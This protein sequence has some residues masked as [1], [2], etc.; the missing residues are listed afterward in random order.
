MELRELETFVVLAEELHFGRTGERLRISTAQ[1]SKTVS[2]LER[3]V[4][5]PLF[6]RTSRRVRLT[7]V[8]E[9]LRSD[10]GP[11]LA[12]IRAGFDRA[13]M[14][15]RDVTGTLRVGFIGAAAGMLVMN[16]AAEFR[17]KYPSC[18]VQIRENQFSDGH[19]GLLREEMIDVLLATLPV[20]EPDLV[21]G[22]VLIREERLLAVSARHPFANRDS[23]SFQDI[24]RT[25]LL[26]SPAGV[27]AYWDAS[28][29]PQLTADGRP[30]ERGPS[31]DT[32]QEML[33]LIGAGQGSYPVPAQAGQFYQRPDV[34]YVPISGAKPFEWALMWRA[35]AETATV[36][37][38]AEVARCSDPGVSSMS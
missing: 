31:F 12:A 14:A 26:R 27:S 33:A 13:V 15:G 18:E 37:A 38:F 8:G 11:A 7:P 3:Q 34:A 35:A 1:V 5:A 30:I 16:V 4:G 32:I 17:Q 36:R 25:R 10:V 9:R 20:E 28:L 19:A 23:I 6:E 24:A 29:A 21:V 2:K 22:P